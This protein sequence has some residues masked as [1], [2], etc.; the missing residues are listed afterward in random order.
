MRPIGHAQPAADSPRR[1]AGLKQSLPCVS[2]EP[3]T[4]DDTVNLIR[5]GELIPTEATHVDLETGERALMRAVLQDAI[6]C[7]LGLA[8]DVPSRD[9]PWTMVQAQ[10]W[11][12]SRDLTWPF[13]FESICNVLGLAPDSLRQRLLRGLSADSGRGAG[14]PGGDMVTVLRTVR[15]R[16]NTH[17]RTLKQRSAT[18]ASP[19]DRRRCA[20][21]RSN[22]VPSN[23]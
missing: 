20:I 8:A 6:L 11:F 4:C 13:S 1:A 17:K 18:S 5:R 14:V 9:R 2:S 19:S 7:L 10:H 21:P 22:R 12:V 16:G 23:R 3:E 15:L